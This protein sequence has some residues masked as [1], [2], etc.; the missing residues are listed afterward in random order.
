MPRLLFVLSV[1]LAASLPAIAQ[2]PKLDPPK[3]FDILDWTPRPATGQAE[4]WEKMRDPQWDDARFRSMNTGP[5]L[6]AS[7]GREVFVTRNSKTVREF[8][9]VAYKGT[10]VKLGE[11]GDACAIFD[12][13]TM[14]LAA[15]WTGGYLE[16]SARR[17]GLLNTP[18][19]PAGGKVVSNAAA[20]QGWADSDGK[21]PGIARAT[22]TAITLP[23]AHVKYRGHYLHGDRVVFSYAV[24]GVGVLE[25]VNA[26]GAGFI[27]SVRVDTTDKPLSLDPGGPVADF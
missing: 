27:R 14:R 17:F 10:A 16:H 5:A 21:F 18:A 26:T 7:F 6:N 2:P 20:S 23:A 9:T 15:G 24:N 3:P 13:A 4:P 22:P 8:E 11:K 19:M 12:R 25:T 1:A